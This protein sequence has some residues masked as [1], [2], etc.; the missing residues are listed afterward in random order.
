MR[1]SSGEALTH[2]GLADTKRRQLLWARMANKFY[3]Q[4]LDR[5]RAIF[6]ANRVLFHDV[7][8]QAARRKFRQDG[9]QATQLR[10][11]L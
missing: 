7:N 9:G 8:R 3:S 11:P 1:F 10:L 6:L 4:L 2:T 5:R